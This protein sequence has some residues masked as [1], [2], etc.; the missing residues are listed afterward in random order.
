M[1]LPALLLLGQVIH[2]LPTTKPSASVIHVPRLIAAPRSF[3]KAPPGFKVSLYAGDLLHP[4][5]MAAAPNGDLFV[6]ET[7]IE[8]AGKQPFD[9]VIMSKGKKS[10]WADHLSY[11]FGVRLAFGHVYLANTDSIVRWP[12]HPGDLTPSGPA[13]TILSGIPSHGYRNHWT[14]NIIFSPDL[15]RL[16]LTIGSKENEDVED[17]G[18]AIIKVFDLDDAG[19]IVGSGRVLANGM[20]NPVGLD[21]NPVTHRLWANVIERDYMGDDLAPDFT[22]SVIDGGFY[23]W[24]WYFAGANV[25]ERVP[26]NPALKS[27]V[28]IPDILLQAH[29]SPIDLKFYTGKMF[30]PRYRNDLFISLHGSQ[31]RSRMNGY[32]VIRVHMDA[33]GHATR[34]WEPFIRGWLPK[35]SNKEIYGRPAGMAILGDGSLLICDDWGGKI[36]RVSYRQ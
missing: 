21:F 5:M 18:R 2:R 25:D 4:R 9:L 1:I 16:Y 12:Y 30:P 26:A 23:G 19:R 29:C 34:Q 31:N 13:E 27:R 20:R 28:L 36:W 7:R 11:P 35:G 8:K 32:M 10:V 33:G 17:P 14:R 3:L 6:V 15:K 22:T 24:P